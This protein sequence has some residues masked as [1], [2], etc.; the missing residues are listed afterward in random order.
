[1]KLY[2]L[3]KDMKSTILKVFG[4]GQVTIP[5]KWREKFD[6]LHFKASMEGGKIILEPIDDYLTFFD[7]DDFNEG[8]GVEIDEF[9]KALQESLK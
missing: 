1:M 2:N 3:Y 4:T 8:K 9:K 6:T 5:K 7:S